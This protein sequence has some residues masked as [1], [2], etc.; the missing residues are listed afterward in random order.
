VNIEKISLDIYKRALDVYNE[1]GSGFN[2]S[3][4]QSALSVEFRDAGV[5]Y[6]REP[7]IEIFYKKQAVGLDRPD[8][9]LLPKGIKGWQMEDPLILETKVSAKLSN[10][11]RQQLKSYFVSIPYNKNTTLQK[12]KSGILL[13][14]LKTEDFEEGEATK[15]A[16]EIEFWGFIKR[17]KS[18]KLRYSLPKTN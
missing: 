6:L 1:L 17:S 11:Y 13:N 2:E 4:L 10:E 8:F 16:V 12:T 9:I 14:F 3:V 18:M 7:H 5:K 15:N